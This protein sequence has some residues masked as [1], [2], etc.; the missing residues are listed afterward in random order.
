M[1]LSAPRVEELVATVAHLTGAEGFP[2]EQTAVV[3]PSARPVARLGLALEPVPSL[4]GWVREEQLDALFLHRPWGVE[5]VDLPSGVG[6]LACHLPFDERLTIGFNPDL[7][8]ALGVSGIEPLGWKEG[9]PLGMIGDFAG[10]ELIE[11][12]TRLFG[13]LEAVERGS[14]APRRVA[15]VGAMTDALVREAAA[16]GAGAYL[17]GQLRVPARRAV[18]ETGMTTIAVGHRR[19]ELWGLHLLARLLGREWP[20]LSA[21]VLD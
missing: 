11:A 16:R 15:A 3:V 8:E 18:A 5:E 17:T 7:A 12:A 1:D 20:G 13:A 9:R 2:A 10:G 21:V 6:V 14:G 4:A 19:S